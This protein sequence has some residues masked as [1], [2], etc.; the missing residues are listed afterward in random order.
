MIIIAVDMERVR[1]CIEH[2]SMEADGSYGTTIRMRQKWGISSIGR[3]RK[4]DHMSGKW[5]IGELKSSNYTISGG[6]VIAKS[7]DGDKGFREENSIARLLIGNSGEGRSRDTG[8][9]TQQRDPVVRKE[10]IQIR[11]SKKKTFHMEVALEAIGQEERW[12]AQ[13]CAMKNQRRCSDKDSDLEE[14][15]PERQG[16]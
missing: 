8:Y 11:Q 1:E 3:M 15:H 16:V 5:A 2:R 13:R 10:G 6:G 12:M 9:Q 4:E 14:K 7:R